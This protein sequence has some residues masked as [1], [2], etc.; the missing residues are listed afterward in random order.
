M[1]LV[2]PCFSTLQSDVAREAEV[3]MIR[4]GLGEPQGASLGNHGTSTAAAAA[5]EG[6][7]HA[8]SYIS[9]KLEDLDNQSV[10]S[11]LKL[12]DQNLPGVHTK[13]GIAFECIS[14]SMRG[15]L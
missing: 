2:A 1:A 5:G 14:T 15:V 11:A 12:T 7:S 13:V 8:N 9:D 3:A 4:E 6:R 10:C